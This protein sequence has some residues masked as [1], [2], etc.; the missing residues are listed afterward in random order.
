MAKSS[1]LVFSGFFFVVLVV[2]QSAYV[3]GAG[4]ASS[5]RDYGECDPRRQVD[6]GNFTS[7]EMCFDGCRSSYTASICLNSNSTEPH[8]CRCCAPKISIAQPSVGGTAST[9]TSLPF[10]YFSL[11]LSFVLRGLFT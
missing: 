6:I 9:T 1:P 4:P 5:P 2:L 3:S 8:P 11:F 10:L 7:C